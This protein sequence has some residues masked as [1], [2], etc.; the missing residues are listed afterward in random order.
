MCFVRG[1]Q[2]GEHGARA[3]PLSPV[4]PGPPQTPRLPQAPGPAPAPTTGGLGSEIQALCSVTLH[5]AQGALKVP[6]GGG[7]GAV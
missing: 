6:G 1:A 7:P 4:L 3:V 5:S 2:R